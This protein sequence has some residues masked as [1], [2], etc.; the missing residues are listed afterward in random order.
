MTNTGED[1]RAAALHIVE[2]F[3]PLFSQKRW[4]EWIEL[5]SDNGV[6]EFPFAPPGRRNRYVGKADI[7]AYMT[8]VAGKMKVDEI[9]YHNVHPM[10]DPKML[11]ME[12]GIR[13]HIIATGAPLNQRYVSIFETTAGKLSQYREYWNPLV[14]MDVNG[15]RDAWTA[16]FGSPAIEGSVA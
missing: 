15:G 3:L 11:C 5:W 4:D 7:L 9:L 13:G 10:L 12:M 16:A 1:E 2:L 6:L 14:S 8:P